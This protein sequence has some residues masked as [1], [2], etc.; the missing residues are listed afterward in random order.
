AVYYGE[1]QY[2]TPDDAAAGHQ[3][4]NVSHRRVNVS[5]SGSA[6][7]IAM[8]ATTQ[9]EKPAIRAWKAADATVTETD[10]QI[11]NDGLLVVSSKATNLGGNVWHYEFA[12][13]NMNADRAIGSFSVPI[14]SGAAVTN[15][16]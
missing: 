6:F 11:P 1:A 10:V 13:Y 12:V 14:P 7:N 15:V 3:N 4:N 8:T 2:V 16:G 9:R 5:G